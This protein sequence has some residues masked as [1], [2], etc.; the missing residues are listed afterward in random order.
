MFIPISSTIHSSGGCLRGA[1]H[2][3]ANNKASANIVQTLIAGTFV[4]Q[5]LSYVTYP[6]LG[7]GGNARLIQNSCIPQTGKSQI[8]SSVPKQYTVLRIRGD[9][10]CLFRALAQSHHSLVW[11][12]TKKGSFNP[13]SCEEETLR[14]ENLRQEIC[15]M[16]SSQ[17]DFIKP[18]LPERDVESYT[19]MMR[20]SSTWGGEPEL[21]MASLVL[22]SSVVVYASEGSNLAKIA[23]YDLFSEKKSADEIA[24]LYSGGI[25]YDSLIRLENV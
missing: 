23:E 20:K 15:D 4:G 2:L 13:L 22:H 6:K 24:V 12:K 14:S 8:Y 9:G 17:E 21:A 25:H 3:N 18:F 11:K 1:R 16:M 7:I 19:H 10:N 5:R